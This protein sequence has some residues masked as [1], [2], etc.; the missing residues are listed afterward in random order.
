MIG[1]F[2]DVV[3][4]VFLMAGIGIILRKTRNVPPGAVSQVTLYV[5]SPALVFHSLSTTTLSTSDLGSISGFTIV[6][7]LVTYPLSWL[8]AKLLKLERETTSGFMLTTLFM[9]S[10]NYGLPMALFAF[11]Q[12]G[13]DRAI[14]FFVTQAT[15]A[16]TL[17]VFVASRSQLDIKSAAFAVFKMPLVYA[18]LAGVASNLLNLTLPVTIGEPVRILG[19]A[20][21]PSMLIVLG[22]Q[23]GEKFSIEEPKALVT[24]CFIRLVISGCV[25]Y[26]LTLLF[27]FTGLS[28]QVLVVVASMPTAVITIILATEFRAKPAFVT[29]A[30]V[31]STGGSLVTLTVLIS[32]VKHFL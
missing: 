24:A 6:L 14:V 28:Q 10:G 19:A 23:I 5:F 15:L 12:A 16:G 1:T 27:G 21:V 11:G 18:S 7:A 17:A 29:S 3:L 20:A 26:S 30:V 9:N 32:L 8:A 4:P 13:L 2:I 25:A 31:L 22:L